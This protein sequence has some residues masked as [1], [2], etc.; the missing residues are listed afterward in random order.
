MGKGYNWMCAA[1]AG[2]GSVLYG[3]DAAVIAGTFSQEGF[4]EYFKPSST[5]LGAIGSCYFA[6]LIVG[7]FFVGLLADRFGRKRTIQIGGVIGLIGA[8]FQTAAQEVGLFFAGRVVAGIASG[9]MLTTV[10]VYQAEIAPPHLRGTMVAFQIVTLNFAGTLASW[11][12]FACNFSSSASFSWRFPIAMQCVP[13]ILLIIG[14]F[15]IPFS[16]RWLISK[17]RHAEAQAVLQ[18]LH[19]D[20]ED[21]TFWEKEYLQISAQLAVEQ[22]EK[23]D[24][25]WHH[26][27]SNPKELRR[28]ATAVASMTSVQCVGAQ[29][30]QVFQSV[31]YAG[32]GYTTR[33]SLLMTGVFGICNMTGGSVNLILIDRLG[34]RKLF[35]SGLFILSVCLGIFAA[36]TAK[37]AQTSDPVWGRTGIAFIMVYIFFFGC[38]FAA[39]PYAY[40]AEVLPTKIR[41]NGMAVA[42]F[43]ANAITLTFSQTAPIALDKIGWKFDLVFIAC[44]VFFF[45]IIFFFFPETKGLTLEEINHAF[46]EKVE[47]ELQDISDEQADAAKIH[48]DVAQVE[49]A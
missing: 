42:L 9:I 17:D 39:S 11:I 14:C 37:F 28:V 1:I 26:I 40:A 48:V 47:F 5:V 45:P 24:A 4:L 41:A 35:L 12:G 6:G 36:A 19:D 18:R 15:F 2:S 8:I 43:V 7:L 10:N 33:R 16:P 22:K 30:I 32:L 31:F 23:A 44:N 38:T 29:T 46:G 34:R 49:R 20:H 13:A 27:L 21:P 25:S 3:Y